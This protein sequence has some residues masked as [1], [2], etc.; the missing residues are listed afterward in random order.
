MDPSTHTN[1][2]WKA[3][4]L[5]SRNDIPHMHDLM[6]IQDKIKV[7]MPLRIELC[8]RTGDFLKSRKQLRTN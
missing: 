5:L 7:P 4:G 1:V 2:R 3:Q 8:G 6:S